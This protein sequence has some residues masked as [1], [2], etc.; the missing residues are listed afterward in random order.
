M[1]VL[2]TCLLRVDKPEGKKHF[3]A[4]YGQSVW[5]NIVDYELEANHLVMSD[6]FRYIAVVDGWG[7]ILQT[8]VMED[9]DYLIVYSSEGNA[10]DGCIFNSDGMAYMRLFQK[11]ERE[12][13]LAM[14]CLQNS[15]YD[16]TLEDLERMSQNKDAHEMAT[17][18]NAILLAHQL[19]TDASLDNTVFVQML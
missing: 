13:S 3:E 15:P 19:P 1:I 17:K 8:F 6:T 10:E 2:N 4:L 11:D 18:V 16:L 7:K 5:Q 9:K 14:W 12:K